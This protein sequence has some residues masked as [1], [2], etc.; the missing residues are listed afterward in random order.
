MRVNESIG[1]ISVSKP[2][3]ECCEG[4]IGL[5]LRVIGVGL[6]AQH[7]PLR[8]RRCILAAI[9]GPACLCK[10]DKDSSG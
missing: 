4:L 9:F 10:N 5:L 7:K 2:L 1:L 3:P 6:R 8:C